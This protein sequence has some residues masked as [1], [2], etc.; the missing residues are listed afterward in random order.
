MPKG[1]RI[2]GGLDTSGVGAI[3][4]GICWPNVKYMEYP[5]SREPKLFG[6]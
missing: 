5:D 2:V 3:L 4:E 6:V 1:L